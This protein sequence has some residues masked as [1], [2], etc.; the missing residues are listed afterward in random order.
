MVNQKRPIKIKVSLTYEE[1]TNLICLLDVDDEESEGF[2]L[3]Q[4]LQKIIE[5]AK[6]RYIEKNLDEL[7]E[8]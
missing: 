5:N 3:S 4:H 6:Y 1:A 2:K 7:L 8:R